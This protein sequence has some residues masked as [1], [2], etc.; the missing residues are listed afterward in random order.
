[1]E[2]STEQISKVVKIKRLTLLRTMFVVY[3]W[4]FRA[5]L[6]EKGAKFKRHEASP[7]IGTPDIES[8][9][10]PGRIEGV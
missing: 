2:L 3:R 1:M 5:T 7:P 9:S 10:Y 4:Q 6:N 8:I